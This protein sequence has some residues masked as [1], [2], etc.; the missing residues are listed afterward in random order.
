MKSNYAS[1]ILKIRNLKCFKGRHQMIISSLGSASLGTLGLH[2]RGVQ[3]RNGGFGSRRKVIKATGV[4]RAGL[5]SVHHS[6]GQA[7]VCGKSQGVLFVLLHSA[8]ATWNTIII[9]YLLFS[10]NGGRYHRTNLY[11]I[12]RIYKASCSDIF[13]IVELNFV[14]QM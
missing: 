10:H 2:R 13:V 1:E 5:F 9:V 12:L 14:E 7:T 6:R 8:L 4:G 11:N 3:H